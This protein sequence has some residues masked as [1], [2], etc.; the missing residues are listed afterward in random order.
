[1]PNPETSETVNARYLAAR[2]RESGS[3]GYG[4]RRRTTMVIET[5]ERLLPSLP[6]ER[7]DVVDFGCADAAMLRATARALGVRHGTST[8]LDVFRAGAPADTADMRFLAVDLF[9]TFPY[10]LPDASQDIAIA[11]AFMKHH[12]APA[13]FLAEVARVL[14]PGGYV[15]LLDPRPFVVKL[16]ML[17]GKFNPDYNPSV[18]SERSVASLLRHSAI[19]LVERSFTRY[20]VA[21]TQ[22][23]HHAG[24]ERALPASVV[25]LLALHQCMVLERT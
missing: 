11:S 12:P 22:A 1:M 23:L 14:R 10:P 19:P 20:W 9:R 17:V 21:P 3:L 8:G 2:Q 25:K 15:V 18:W 24:L 16:G 5:V 7:L 4:L 13:R 6:R